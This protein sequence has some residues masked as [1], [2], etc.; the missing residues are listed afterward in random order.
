MQK[1]SVLKNN[2]SFTSL[3]LPYSIIFFSFVFLV[4]DH[5]LFSNS[6]KKFL[7]SS[8]E[9]LVVFQIFFITPHIIASSVTLIDR[10]YIKY[11]RSKLPIAIILFLIPFVFMN[12]KSAAFTGA[13]IWAIWTIY[14]V[15]HQQFGIGKMFLRSTHHTL[16][17]GFTFLG[18]TT[19]ILIFFSVYKKFGLFSDNITLFFLFC[20]ITVG[21]F[22]VQ[23]EQNKKGRVYVLLN[24]LLITSGY[25]F[26]NQ[27]LPFFI[28]LIPR[29]I[30]DCTAFYFYSKHDTNR[31]KTK[32]HNL[33]YRLFRKIVPIHSPIMTPVLGIMIAFPLTY[34]KTFSVF[35]STALTIFFGIT[36][37]HYYTEGFM[38]KNGS[39]HR[40]QLS[41]KV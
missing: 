16:Y 39:I 22:I 28:I 2:I 7:P 21:I 25:I 33:I 35:N 6:L 14:H 3:I 17:K 24:I 10:E 30:H 11:Y 13:V 41:I 4:V 23:T 5:F 9:K 12:F 32:N 18:L 37:V 36:L 20:F 40:Q 29:I 19:A 38:W 26:Y 27:L 31:N 8:P 15:I 34:S 1:E